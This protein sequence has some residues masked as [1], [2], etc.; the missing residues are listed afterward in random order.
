[1]FGKPCASETFGNTTDGT[2]TPPLKK[3]S[4]ECR[5]VLPLKRGSPR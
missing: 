5:L 4:N 2:E 3:L 1:V